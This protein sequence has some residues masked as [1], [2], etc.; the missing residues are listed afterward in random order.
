M[1]MLADRLISWQL[2]CVAMPEKLLTQL[3][4]FDVRDASPAP[5]TIR[6]SRRARRLTV[7]V[8]V[9]GRVEVVVPP[10]TSERAVR[11]FVHRHRQWIETRRERARREQPSPES[12][13]PA[14][15]AL[16]AFDELWALRSVTGVARPRLATVSGS[17]LELR[18]ALTDVEAVRRLLR[19][20]VVARA[21]LRLGP[22]LAELA[23]ERGFQFSRMSVRRQR[24]RWGSCSAR[25]TIS[26]NG[27]LAFQRPAVVRYLLLHELAHTRH[28]NHSARFWHLVAEHEPDWRSLDRELLS[29]WRQVPAWMFADGE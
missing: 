7:R 17:V 29:G 19:T 6:R 14:S 22:W 26:L 16:A 2:R 10:R 4:L 23:R 3:S 20:W 27:C 21:T 15:I 11:E 25:G 24:T 1:F 5:W 13:P 12:F 18:G 28:M 8:F 9:T